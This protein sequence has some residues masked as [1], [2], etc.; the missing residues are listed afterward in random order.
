MNILDLPKTWAWR[1]KQLD[2]SQAEFAELAGVSLAALNKS[3][4]Q[5]TSPTLSLVSKVETKLRELK[6]K[7][8]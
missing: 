6:E 7:N 1:I 3:I 4:N 5:R 2:L 8:D